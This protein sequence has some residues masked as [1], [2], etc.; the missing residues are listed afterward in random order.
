VLKHSNPLLRLSAVKLGAIF[1]LVSIVPLG[2]LTYFS[3]SLASDAVRRDAKER[4]SLTAALSAEGVRQELQGL[5]GIVESYAA[6]PSLVR[7]M[8]D[9]GQTPRDAIVL[10]HHLR[11]LRNAQEG[12]YTTFLAKPDGTLVDVVPATPSILGKNYSFRDWFRGLERSGYTYV[13]RAYRTQATGTPL[14]VAVATYIRD[15]TSNQVGILVAAFNLEHLQNLSRLA[16]TQNIAFTL[17]DQRGV[18][19]AAPGQTPTALVS[20]RADSRVEAALAGWTGTAELDTPD[21]RLLSAYAP[22]VP[23]IGWTVTASVPATSAFAAVGRLRSTVLTI[24]GVLGLVLLGALLLLIRVLYERQ[25]SREHALYL[26]DINRAVL[27]SAPDSIFLADLQGKL[28]LKNKSLDRMSDGRAE[29]WFE[30]TVYDHLVAASERMTNGGEWCSQIEAI[31]ADPDLT[32]DLEAQRTDGKIFHMYTAPVRDDVGGVTGRIFVARDRTAEHEAERLKSELVATVSHELRTPLSSIVGF[33]E[34]LVDREVDSK[35]RERYVA[36]IHG[37][38]KRLAEL[39]NDFLDLQRIEEGDFTLALEPFELIE[40]L[41]Q[42]VELFSANGGKHEIELEAADGELTLLGERD[43]VAQVVV[44]LL[45]NAIK[46]SPAGGSVSVVAAIRN[47]AVRVSITDTG[48]GIAADHQRM[49]FT[50]FY[51]VDSSDTREI[52]GTGLGLALCREIVEAHGGRIGF[53]SIEGQGSTFWFELPA[54][55]QQNGQSPRRVLVIEDDPAA[56]SL[57]A[58]YIGGNGF[59]V[60]IAATGEQGLARAIEDPPS[61]ICL[62]MSLPGAVDGWQLLSRLRD[63]PDTAKTPI[64]IC[65]G[66]NGRDR[67]AALGVTDFI[68]KPF[69]HRQ[70]RGAIERLLPEGG[71]RVLVVDDDPAVR[72]LVFE[73]L[74]GNGFDLREAVDG[75]SALAEIAAGKPDVLILDLMMPGLDGFH[76]LERLQEDPATRL[77]PVI[78]LTAHRLTALEREQLSRLTVALLDKSA[79]SPQELH[80]LVARMLA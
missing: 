68:A 74:H 42:K 40:L 29:E 61:L 19:L 2:C 38:A 31:V 46:Y 65:T 22:V 34:L 20:L 50:K 62:D 23:D 69:S 48:L 59:E 72:R 14:V 41:R 7:A 45:S 4:M 47:G 28:V 11:E 25:K 79:Y 75:E 21:G 12:I 30:G 63:R 15:S 36:T 5:K 43:R 73:T 53:D 39:I 1:A 16:S 80:R 54:P 10:R 78:V 64:I 49:L 33:A 27:D 77:L 51:R 70:I 24:A 76:V 60:E 8:R 17:T 52:G 37:E 18:I 67:A 71:G 6:R 32:T 44:N 9:D 35:T 56:A 3:I 55:Q 13:S 57:L 66:R 58:E 26:A